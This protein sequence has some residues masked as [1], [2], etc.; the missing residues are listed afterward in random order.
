[1][2]ER[3]YALVGTG[4]AFNHGPVIG[5]LAT[6]LVVDGESDLFDLDHFPLDRF[7]DAPTDEIYAESM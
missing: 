7:E 5:R 1:M 3:F 2:G 6:D 4:H